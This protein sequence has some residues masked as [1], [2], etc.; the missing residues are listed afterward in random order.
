MQE[1]MNY[2]E[3]RLSMR[4]EAG[5][6]GMAAILSGIAGWILY[7]SFWGCLLIIVIFPLYRNCY[8]EEKKEERKQAKLATM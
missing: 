4:E 7:Q 2:E 6:L 3:Y 1:Y 5:C 8:R